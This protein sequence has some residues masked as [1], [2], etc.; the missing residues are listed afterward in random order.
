VS[1][2]ARV[3]IEELGL[4]LTVRPVAKE[5]AAPAPP[6]LDERM[7]LA[8]RLAG[9]I[10]HEMNN[11]LTAIAGYNELILSR[12][13]DS[14]PLRRDALEIEKALERARELM[15]RLLAVAGRQVDV[16]SVFELDA[17][18]ER[19]EP[20]LRRL[21][22]ERVELAIERSAGDVAVRASAEQLGDAVALLVESACAGMGGDGVLRV[23]TSAVE[24]DGERPPGLAPGRYARLAVVDSGPPL[25]EEARSRIFEPFLGAL[26]HGRGQGLELAAAYGLVTQNGGVVTVASGPEETTFA[27]LLPVA[28][29]VAAGEP[30]ELS[31]AERSSRETVL[32]ADD[33]NVVR[34][35]VRE[36]LERFGYAVLEARD[37][38]EALALAERWTGPIDLLLTDVRMPRMSGP[39]LAR[40][41][42]TIRPGVRVLYMSGLA[43]TDVTRELELRPAARFI[44]KPMTPSVLLRQVRE[45][46]DQELEQPGA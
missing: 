5:R 42:R 31:T 14:N 33:E 3:L 40:R 38:P 11:V 37:G 7:A 46:L 28:E 16:A 26:G 24:V 20:L 6:D 39:E 41:L 30:G 34:G 36:T 35:V 1:E 25:D 32:L 19:L 17:F 13:S 22:G 29:D 8:A 15:H 18:V 44:D 23:E 27:V 4:E 2:Q 9:G 10:A 43:D 45:A 12:M 21:A